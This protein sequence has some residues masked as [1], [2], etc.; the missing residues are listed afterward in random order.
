MTRKTRREIES[1]LED[2]TDDDTSPDEIVFHET[3]VGTGWGDD[4]EDGE[5]RS[6][7]EVFEL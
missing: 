6:E 7:T 5:T 2:I 1:T 4:L 3:V